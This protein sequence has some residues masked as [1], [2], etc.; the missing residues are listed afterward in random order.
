MTKPKTKTRLWMRQ[1][2]TTHTDSRYEIRSE[3]QRFGAFGRAFRIETHVDQWVPAPEEI[4]GADAPHGMLEAVLAP[5]SRR[6]ERP[7]AFSS[8][9]RWR[10]TRRWAEASVK[11][12]ICRK[13]KRIE[14]RGARETRQRER[15]LKAEF[16]AK[17]G[18]K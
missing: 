15:T 10:P 2:Y 14:R 1:A 8:H 17:C 7:S 9:K 18:C 4:V 12:A 16:D 11:S 3:P 6:Y 13:R 5:E